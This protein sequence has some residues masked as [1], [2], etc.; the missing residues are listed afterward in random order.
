M[1]LPIIIRDGKIEESVYIWKNII[2]LHFFFFFFIFLFLIG[3]V[4]LHKYY[5]GIH[6]ISGVVKNEYP[7]VNIQK[8]NI[9]KWSSNTLPFNGKWIN[10]TWELN[11]Q[12]LPFQILGWSRS[13][14]YGYLISFTRQ[15]ISYILYLLNIAFNGAH[16]TMNSYS[17]NSYVFCWKQTSLSSSYLPTFKFIN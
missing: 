2:M 15:L 7:N 17:F 5:I 16:L 13:N 6:P 12:P 1:L 11:T 14:L 3:S 4:C 9:Q 8:L 10:G